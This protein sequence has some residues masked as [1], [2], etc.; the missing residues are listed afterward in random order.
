MCTSNELEPVDMIELCRYF[1]SKQP[2]SASRADSPRF[3]ILGI[4]PY[5]IAEGTLMR[6]FLGPSDNPNLV[7]GANLGAEASVNA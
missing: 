6:N 1:I 2:T 5:E 3:Y 4:A 7:N